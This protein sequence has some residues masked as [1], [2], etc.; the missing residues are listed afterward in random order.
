MSE[1]NH[2]EADSRI[3]VH[4]LHAVSSD[5]AKSVQ[6]RTVDTDVIVI[7]ICKVHDILARYPETDI[8]VAFGMGRHFSL[9]HINSICNHLGESKSRSLPV[10]H[11]LTGCD[12]TSGF[13]GKSKLLAWNTWNI[14]PGLSQS[15][16]ALAKE[17]FQKLTLSSD[18]FSMIERFV[19]L[20]YDKTSPLQ[21]VND[22]RMALFC[23]SVK[24]IERLPP[25]QV[26]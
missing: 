6:V 4:L 16:E 14:F 3:V 18:I 5:N 19:I 7:L 17:P 8:W 21:S 9:K 22:A 2:E 1:C 24:A 23:T 13:F 11:A 12:T 15:L 26:S 10:F 25:T 20:M